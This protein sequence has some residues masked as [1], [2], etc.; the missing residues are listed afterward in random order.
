VS[1]KRPK[2]FTPRVY[3]L[4]NDTTHQWLSP[5]NTWTTVFYEACVFQN[6]ESVCDAFE[7]DDLPDGAK[8]HDCEIF[9]A[10]GVW[11]KPPEPNHHSRKARKA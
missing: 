11:L 4:Y 6:F 7:A 2:R 10:Q 3:F 8:F 9:A 5:H 1:D